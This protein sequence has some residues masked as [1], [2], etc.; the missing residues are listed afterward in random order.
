MLRLSGIHLTVKIGAGTMPHLQL[1]DL[2]LYYEVTGKGEPLLLLHGLGS[3]GRDWELQLP[4]FSRHF[5]V[6]TVDV[7]GH[8]RS[9]KPPGP[10][11]VPQFAAD[12][13]ALMREL[14][15][16]PAHLVGISMG[17][18]I[19][20]QLALAA[21]GCVRSLV[22]V[23][24]G[25][26]L[27]ARSWLQRLQLWQRL[28]VVRFS[29][30]RRI[31]TFIGRRLFPKPEQALLLQI[32]IERWAEN[33]KQAYSHAFEALIGWSVTDRLH[34]IK[35]PVLVIA[36]EHDYV[37]LAYQEACAARLATARLVVIP[38]SRHATPADQP[39]MFNRTVLAFLEKVEG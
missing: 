10:Y 13:A 22:L 34:E 19:A 16:G 38:D 12:I 2:A 4:E 14:V 3:S 31:G 35:Q 20:L 5:Q 25:P 7:R 26:E 28:L 17:G 33:D 6:I 36:A 8:G 15:L 9:S 29:S 37:P 21:P 30:M 11:S 18:M 32:F 24:S 23:N 1:D 27:V 39:E